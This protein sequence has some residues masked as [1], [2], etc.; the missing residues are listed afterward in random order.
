MC[1]FYTARRQMFDI[2]PVVS[3]HDVIVVDRLRLVISQPNSAKRASPLRSRV[4]HHYLLLLIIIVIFLSSATC[5]AQLESGT[6][7]VYVS[8]QCGSANAWQ[9]TSKTDSIEADTLIPYQSIRY[10][11]TTSGRWRTGTNWYVPW[12][13]SWVFDRQYIKTSHPL[14]GRRHSS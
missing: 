3:K 1:L 2:S 4:H 14:V 13:F 10:S 8:D 6:R 7:S 9:M 12:N 5:V 11:T